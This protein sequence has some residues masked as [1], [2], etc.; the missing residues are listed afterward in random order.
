MKK[1]IKF[2]LIL[3]VLAGVYVVYKFK[4]ADEKP[5]QFITQKVG[6]GDV[7]ESIEAVGEVFAISKVDIGA[8]VS[9]QINKLYVKLGD[10]VK[11]GDK[12]ADIDAIRQINEV[13]KQEAQLKIY[14]SNL[15]SKDIALE[16]AKKKF[17]REKILFSKNATSQES[18]ESAENS[19]EI[20]KAN[21]IEL[22]ASITQTNINLNTAKT[23]LNYTKILSPIDG[24]IVA[25]AI[26]EG[27]T[28]NSAQN[29]PIIATVANLDKMEIKMQIAE[30]DITKIKVGQSIK[31]N[32]LSDINTKFESVLNKIDPA[33]TAMSDSLTKSSSSSLGAVYYYA[34]FIVDNKNQNLRVGMSVQN[35][36]I[37]NEAKNTLLVPL[38]AIQ[39]DFV[40]ILENDI[41]FKKAVKTGI[42]DGVNIQILSGLDENQSV[43]ISPISEEY[44]KKALNKW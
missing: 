14:K 34:R 3:L 28:L 10:K 27:Q 42:N 15:A 24:T 22:E 19:Y 39:D 38:S 13:K 20:A 35:S 18:L 17:E 23:N 4:F 29:T 8:Q 7:Y 11:K 33:N 41:L 1:I 32:I 16:I 12:I 25:V 2:A 43:I 6:I 37:I 26:E 30:G 36:I 31:F 40:Y 9:G 44:K 5:P 21:V